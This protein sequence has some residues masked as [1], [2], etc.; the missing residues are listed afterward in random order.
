MLVHGRLF[1]RLHN[2][3]TVAASAEFQKRNR[4][5]FQLNHVHRGIS[6][7]KL[8]VLVYITTRAHASSL[9]NSD[10]IIFH[11]GRIISPD[12]AARRFRVLLREGV[13]LQNGDSELL[14]RGSGG[15][16]IRR[17]QAGS[18]KWYVAVRQM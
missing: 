17:D 11:C 5:H 14:Q 12:T 8:V 15:K 6:H 9:S 13:G 7:S 3:A 18:A 10:T 2:D 4:P 16:T 1:R